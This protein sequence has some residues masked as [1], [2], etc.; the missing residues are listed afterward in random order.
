MN[1]EKGSFTFA[2]ALLRSESPEEFA[3][4]LEDLSRDIESRNVIQRM[5]VSDIANLTWEILRYRRAKAAILNNAS[6][7]ALVKVLR[8]LFFGEEHLAKGDEAA[9][10]LVSERAFDPE[11]SARILEVL[12]E[13]NL[14]P[15]AAEGEALRMRLSEIEKIDRLIVSA[16]SRRDK[17]LSNLLLYNESISNQLRSNSDRFLDLNA[18][19]ARIPSEVT[20]S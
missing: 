17:A 9:R 2:P 15:W 5:Y 7:P 6:N 8:P 11:A 14:D 4:L 13:A 18:A 16:E 3:A 10:D 19:T 20:L 1:I 12:D